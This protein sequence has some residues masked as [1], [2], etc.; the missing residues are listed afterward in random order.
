MATISKFTLSTCFALLLLCLFVPLRAHAAITVTQLTQAGSEECS[1]TV[2]T[3]SITPTPGSMLLVFVMQEKLA[4]Y[5]LGTV[6]VS[7]NG[8][9]WVSMTSAVDSTGT[10]RG[11]VFRAVATSPTPGALSLVPSAT[12]QNCTWHVLEVQG[13]DTR[14][15]DGSMAIGQTVLGFSRIDFAPVPAPLDATNILFTGASAH[16]AMSAPAGYTELGAQ[17]DCCGSRDAVFIE[18][19]TT[20]NLTATVPGADVAIGIKILPVPA[21]PA[22]AALTITPLTT[23]GNSSCSTP[24]D[25][26]SYAPT[27]GAL[28][29]AFV[30]QEASV[31]STGADI[32]GN[33]L[34]WVPVATVADSGNTLRGT[35]VKATGAAPTEGP[36]TITPVGANDNC[37]WSIVQVTGQD[38]RESIGQ[39]AIGT[40]TSPTTIQTLFSPAFRNADAASLVFTGSSK[41]IA[42]TAPEAWEAVGEQSSGFD[43][44]VSVFTQNPNSHDSSVT[45]TGGSGS[46]LSIG[47]KVRVGAGVSTSW[48]HRF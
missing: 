2:S 6:S 11:S 23:G 30:L 46:W 24:V 10:R 7:G 45:M 40:L 28:V 19:P 38:E 35:L 17:S 26:A 8:L 27:P 21:E 47:V 43:S 18:N 34:T 44:R 5:P 15:T 29:L 25:T 37:T 42:M 14:G 16:D 36:L 41:D 20:A 31:G 9:T 3:A 32:S 33:G 39:A 48:M 4:D 22:R 13:Y 12:Q 1:G